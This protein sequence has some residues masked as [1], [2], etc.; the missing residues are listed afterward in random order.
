VREQP[1]SVRFA[2]AVADDAVPLDRSVSLDRLAASITALEGLGPWTAQYLALRL[3]EPDACPITDLGIQ[4]ALR[5][6]A[7]AAVGEVAERWR[8]WRAL[9]TTHLWFAEGA[10]RDPRVRPSAARGAA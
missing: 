5:R 9:A 6:Y 8:P 2:R 10:A 4:R 1:P 7:A 3:G